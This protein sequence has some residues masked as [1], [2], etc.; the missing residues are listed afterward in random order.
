MVRFETET[1]AEAR[2]V[3]ERVGGAGVCELADRSGGVV[4]FALVVV[5]GAVG[6]PPL[7]A[8]AEVDRSAAG[9]R[10]M[11]P[12]LEPPDED[13]GLCCPSGLLWSLF[14]CGCDCEPVFLML[15]GGPFGEELWPVG[16]ETAPA[17]AARCL[18]DSSDVEGFRL[19]V[20]LLEARW[21]GVWLRGMGGI[22]SVEMSFEKE[23][24]AE[25]AS[26][27]DVGE[28][29]FWERMVLVRSGDA[30]R[31]IMSLDLA[32]WSAMVLG[33]DRS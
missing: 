29:I 11:P 18:M 14:S 8:I 7:L 12:S 31:S 16:V 2:W 27:G 26:D 5:T 20:E 17:V 28:E 23:T 30:C 25:A 6:G 32:A 10:D 22:A 13:G 24:D 15:T 1:P 9:R 33:W 19:D 3:A 4:L 21:P